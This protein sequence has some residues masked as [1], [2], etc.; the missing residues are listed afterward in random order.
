MSL[1]RQPTLQIS[2]S[3]HWILRVTERQSEP[4]ITYNLHVCHWQGRNKT[5]T[6]EVFNSII[7]QLQMVFTSITHV[8]FA[9][10]CNSELPNKRIICH[11]EL[12]FWH[13]MSET[14]QGSAMMFYV[15]L[16]KVRQKL[17]KNQS[18]PW[19]HEWTCLYIT[20]E[21]Q[22]IPPWQPN[23]LSTPVVSTK[24]LQS[25]II[26]STCRPN[27]DSWGRLGLLPL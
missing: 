26:S 16:S 25:N 20:S 15:Q 2:H 22:R 1:T 9:G 24:Q 11:W 17:P 13:G 4:K 8:K 27:C 7:H 19:G 21:K 18:I 3:G 12:S 10:C 14:V 23:I 6:S 5:C